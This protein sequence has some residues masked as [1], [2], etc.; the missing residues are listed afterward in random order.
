MDFETDTKSIII[1]DTEYPLDPVV[2]NLIE[3]LH[4]DVE[5]LEEVVEYYRNL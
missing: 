5:Y 2:W 3:S 1:N 4:I